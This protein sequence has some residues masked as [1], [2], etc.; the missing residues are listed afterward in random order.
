[1]EG[2][3]IVG[4]ILFI[5][6]IA[7]VSASE[8]PEAKKKKLLKVRDDNEEYFKAETFIQAI[9][10]GL[11]KQVPCCNK[12]NNNQFQ[13]WDVFN[14][15]ETVELKYRCV[16]CKKI[17]SAPISFNIEGYDDKSATELIISK[18]STY[19]GLYDVARQYDVNSDEFIFLRNELVYDFLDPTMRK[20]T[21]L[22]SAITFMCDYN[23]NVEI[24]VDREEKQ[25]SRKIPSSVQDRVWRRDE[26]KCV[27]CGSNENL[28]FDHIIPFSKGGANTYRNIQLLCEKCNRSKSDKF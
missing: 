18:I 15:D 20:G 1:M 25:R 5:I 11:S 23:N 19:I 27:K 8:S 28:E 10:S 26:G 22:I 3:I 4:V 2:L 13:W 21:K 12:C 16:N 9:N 7:F 6:F 24:T 17:H 14:S